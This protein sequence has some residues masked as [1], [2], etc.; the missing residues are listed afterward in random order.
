VL[1]G[2]RE[3]SRDNR[4]LGKFDL[5]GIPP[6]PRGVPQIEVTFDIDANGIMNVSAKDL[7][8]GKDQKI[9][10]EA[11]SGLHEDEISRMVNDA[12]DHAEED[13]RRKEEITLKNHADQQVYSAE[14]MLAD[15]GDKIAAADK[16]E[17]EAAL[18][19][20]K[21]AL[22]TAEADE[23]KSKMERLSS[24]THRV[25]ESVY[26]QT[27][28]Q[29]GEAGGEDFTAPSSDDVVDAEFEVGDDEERI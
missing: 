25:S 21:G 24:V 6:A 29:G 13:R 14:R 9:K 16:A 27:A 4:T 2:E 17:I 11:S 23:I 22:D 8:T 7:G 18:E 28:N 19:D 12:E 20:L 10:I 26:Q 15:M 1:Q 5:V 3:L